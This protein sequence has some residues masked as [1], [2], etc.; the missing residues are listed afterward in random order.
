MTRENAIQKAMETLL[1]SFPGAHFDLWTDS[2]TGDTF[3]SIEEREVYYGEAYREAVGR[4]ET[5]L[6]WPN[7]IHGVFFVTSGPE[8]LEP[9][10]QQESREELSERVSALEAAAGIL[11]SEVGA[12]RTRLSFLEARLAHLQAT[13]G[14]G[15]MNI[16]YA[17]GTAL[18]FDSSSSV[19]LTAAT[20]AGVNFIEEGL[21]ED[22]MKQ[23]L[24]QATG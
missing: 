4:L 2:E 19:L 18:V 22:P 6:L 16:G 23:D 17:Q 3:I 1:S 7:S 14:A 24:L 9:E 12:L 8:N 10:L 5:Q 20:A 11:R 13:R 15:L 21:A